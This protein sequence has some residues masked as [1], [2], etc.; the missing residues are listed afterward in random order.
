MGDNRFSPATVES[1]TT[2]GAT[3]HLITPHAGNIEHLNTDVGTFYKKSNCR[4]MLEP[5]RDTPDIRPHARTATRMRQRQKNLILSSFS[6]Q[7]G[8]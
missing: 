4:H 1:T 3:R 7:R 8:L 2:V 6:S 5:D